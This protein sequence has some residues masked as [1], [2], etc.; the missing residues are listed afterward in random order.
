MENMEFECDFLKE[1]PFMYVDYYYPY[2]YISN[3]KMCQI[4]MNFENKNGTFVNEN[5]HKYCLS[6]A[7]DFE[8][9]NIYNIYQRYNTIY[10]PE[11]QLNIS[12]NIF[13]NK[14]NRLIWELFL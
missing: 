1:K 14:K 4:A 12:K 6:S 7:C 13:K 3:S 2:K 5:C 8:H 9:S 11:I 10:K